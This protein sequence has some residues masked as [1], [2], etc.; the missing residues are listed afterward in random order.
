M[1]VDIGPKIG[2]EGEAQF[3]RELNQ[4]IQGYKTLEAEGKAVTAAME[5]ETDAEKKS[6][7][8]KDLLNRQIQTLREKLALQE[9]GLMDSARSFGEADVKTQKWQQA[10]HETNAAISKLEHQLGSMDQEVE[11]TADSFQEAG[12]ATM[13]WAEVLKGSLLASA[14]KS[15]L[16]WMKDTVGGLADKTLEASRAGTAYADKYLTMATVTGIGADQLQRY[17]YMAELIDV[18]LDTMTGSLTKMTRSMSSAV[19]GKGDAAA[20]WATLGISI[21]TAEGK[22]RSN[23]EVMAETLQALGKIEDQTERDT[24][25]MAIFGKSAQD[26]NPMIAAGKELLEQFD[27]EAEDVGYVLSGPA[28]KALGKQ[29]DAMDRLDKRTEAL[30]NRFAAR[31]APSMEKAYST[32]DKTLAS[33]RVRRGLDNLSDGIGSLIEKGA[34]LASRVLPDLFGVFTMGDD[35]LRLYSDRQL[36]LLEET[37]ALRDRHQELMDEYKANAGTIVDQTKRTEGLWKELQ[38]LVDETGHVKDKDQE[39]VDFILNQLNEALGTEYTRNGEII[40]QYQTMQGE[41]D[42]IIKKREAEALLA[43]GAAGF[44]E[45]EQKKQEALDK[46][47][48]LAEEVARAQREADQAR[49]DYVNALEYAERFDDGT[50]E[51]ETKRLKYLQPYIKAAEDARKALADLSA[52]YEEAR[53]TAAKYY[54]DADRWA[55]AQEAAAREDYALVVHILTDEFGVTLDYYKEKKRLSDQ[56][57]RD[58]KEKVADQERVIAE[59]KRNLDAG[60]RGFSEAG[61]QELQ[62]YV[63]EARRILDGRYVA[64]QWLAGLALGLRDQNKLREVGE[65]AK[66]GPERIVRAGRETLEIHSPSGVAKWMAEMY[67]RGWVDTLQAGAKEMERASEAQARALMAGAGTDSRAFGSYGVTAAPIG[68]YT[69]N[70][71]SARN[72]YLGGITIRVEG[73][74]AVNED[75]LAQRVVVRLTEELQR[76]ERAS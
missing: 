45:A 11:D 35:R 46:S 3:R 56:E 21:T 62:D 65:A 26:L 51:G 33:P 8:Q 43:S 55:K 13:G 69:T 72:T 54:Q 30:S 29:Q 76:A 14:V 59:Y 57:R 61:L 17:A 34:E 2:I 5:G 63:D 23:Q 27:R 47:A 28:L 1:A 4:V 49:R 42:K 37:Q 39:R 19:K 15:G 10:V 32:W 75:V 67:N 44:A 31:L 48:R 22:L 40:E 74:G 9:K 64:Q 25:S 18:D 70:N 38:S 71:S 66:M 73:S 41:I 24:L 20:A 7:A 16:T 52:D 58:L 68:T 50:A 60:L 12:E 6:A 36:G 53:S